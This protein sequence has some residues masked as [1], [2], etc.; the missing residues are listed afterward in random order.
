[1]TAP[2]VIVGAGVAGCVAARTL[3]DQGREVL[4]LE[5][6][7][8]AERPAVLD[9][10]DHLRSAEADAWWFPDL[11]LRG[12]GLGGSSAVNGMVLD[13][14]HPLDIKRWGWDD[15]LELQRWLLERWQR[16]QVAAGPFTEA[17]GAC[18]REGFPTATSTTVPGWSGWAPLSLAFDGS[19]RSSAADA[20][21]TPSSGDAPVPVR[22]GASVAKIVTDGG[23]STVEL[24]TGEQI[25]ASMVLVAAGNAGSP[26]LLVRSGLVSA[27]D[28]AEPLNHASTAIIVELDDRLQS[29]ATPPSATSP[30]APSPSAPSSHMLRTVSGLTENTVDLQMLVMDHTGSDENGRRH[31]AIIVSALEPDRQKVLIAGIT[32]A[33][34]WL[35]SIDGVVK[36]S[37]SD[38]P[39]P[40]Q[41]HSCSL[42]HAPLSIP[43][44]HVIDSSVL[45]ALPHTNPM[46]SIAIGARR[47]AL[48]LA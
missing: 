19:T 15:A 35:H 39:C 10:L 22:V 43:G 7:P 41:H 3:V 13:A 5:A 46:L 11:P 47:A 16:T 27:D 12:C 33:L 32:Q 24:V 18:V 40:V 30:S 45:P 34:R 28:V 31:G 44:V 4:L 9:G 42:T 29:A 2:V 20:F 25:G 23:T 37:L 48:R 38:D 36:V 26:A 6:G 21:L 1:M 8:G 17:F 14:I